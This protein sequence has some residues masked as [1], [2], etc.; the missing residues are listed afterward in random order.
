MVETMQC[1]EMMCHECI[2]FTMEIKTERTIIN[3]W[4]NESKQQELTSTCG[5]MK[6]SNRN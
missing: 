3:V 2:D 1:D 5:L 6:V 4:V